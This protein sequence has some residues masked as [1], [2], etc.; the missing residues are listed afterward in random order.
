M[1]DDLFE[2]AAM[3]GLDELEADGFEADGLDE[4][5]ELEADGLDELDEFEADGL[6][7]LDD[8]GLDAMD[9]L[10]E[11]TDDALDDLDYAGDFAF[12]E[13]SDLF[14]PGAP[15]LISGPAASSLMNMLNPAVMDSMDAD[16]V[17]A[18]FG[19]IGGFLKRAARSA[20]PFLRRALPMVQKVA[21]FAGPWGRLVSAG[22]GGVQGLMEGKGLKGALQGAVGGLI[23]GAGGAIAQNLLGSVLSADAAEDDAAV[24]AMADLFD[25]AAPH[26]PR[27]GV[28]PAA[29][30]VVNHVHVA[31]GRVHPRHVAHAHAHAHHAHGHA[32][33]VHG[34]P[35]VV[36]PHGRRLHAAVALPIGAGLVSRVIGR[37]GLAPALRRIG[38]SPALHHIRGVV[39]RLI[40]AERQLLRAAHLIPGSVGRRLRTMRHIGHHAAHL[41]RR[42]SATS[43]AAAVRVI[44]AAVNAAIRHVVPKVTSSPSVLVRAPAVAAA[45]VRKRRKIMRRTPIDIVLRAHILRAR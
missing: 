21:G 44:P 24:D 33:R 31:T 40:R 29:H 11:L 39:P 34:H 13:A 5:D 18:F 6:D 16:E 10:D 36:H 8:D 45:R 37:H 4:L 30:R 27:A 26:H 23:P 41:V 12:D 1:S 22:L 25:A 43:P 38:R 9:E 32:H 35:H 2:D 20:A 7:D 42:R 3:E 19:R 15:T 28:R 17:D 14:V